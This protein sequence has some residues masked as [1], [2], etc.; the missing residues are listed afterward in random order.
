MIELF[1][2]RLCYKRS[3]DRQED[4]LNPVSEKE[5]RDSLLVVQANALIHSNRF[6]FLVSSDQF[7]LLSFISYRKP[8]IKDLKLLGTK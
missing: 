2:D 5:L 3:S 8:L 4:A 6:F 1:N 7:L